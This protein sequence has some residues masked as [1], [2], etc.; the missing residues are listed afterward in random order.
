LAVTTLAAG[1]EGIR[2]SPDLPAPITDIAYTRDDVPK[3]PNSLEE[4][5]AE[6][7]KDTDL[8]AVLDP[9]FI[10]LALAVKKF[11]VETTTPREPTCKER[12]CPLFPP[13]SRWSS[14][15]EAPSSGALP[16]AGP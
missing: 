11:E 2:S 16:T 9:E 13:T 4:A 10:K 7:E 1:L 5:I 14:W 15:P 12:P 3:L 6:F 8:H